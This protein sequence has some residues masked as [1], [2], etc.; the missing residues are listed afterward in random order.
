MRVTLFFP[1][2]M[3]CLGVGWAQS[4][5]QVTAPAQHSPIPAPTPDRSV[6]KRME[7]I[8]IEAA[9][10]RIEELRVGGETRNITVQPKG[11]MPRYEVQPVSGERSWKILDF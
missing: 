11:R 2:F 3:C 5:A 8:Q 7:H 4:P 10:T 9:G 6:E 1:L